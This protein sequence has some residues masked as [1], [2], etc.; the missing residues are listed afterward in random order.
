MYAFVFPLI[1][2]SG[3]NIVLSRYLAGQHLHVEPGKAAALLFAALPSTCSSPQPIGLV[4]YL[5][6]RS[7]SG[8][9]LG[10][11]LLY[12]LPAS[13]SPWMIFV[14]SIKRYKQVSFSFATG[15][16]VAGAL[17]LSDPETRPAST[18]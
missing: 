3:L 1:F 9:E 5:L 8:S 11:Y 4:F 13:S 6:S 7:T 14:S 17:S 10:A 2:T 18:R 16:A 12:I 15:M